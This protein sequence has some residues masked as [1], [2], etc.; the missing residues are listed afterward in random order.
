MVSN[1]YFITNDAQLF[2]A[3]KAFSG[4]INLEKVVSVLAG[5]NNLLH[6]EIYNLLEKRVGKEIAQKLFTDAKEILAKS[7]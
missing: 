3:T 4:E 6:L 1:P 2:S 7:I 5:T